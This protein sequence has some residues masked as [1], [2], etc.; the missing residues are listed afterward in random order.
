MNF[1]EL[2]DEVVL[3]TS[4]PDLRDNKIKAAVKM[5]TLK[6]HQSDYYYKDVLE[7]PLQFSSPNFLQ[8]I[9]YRNL[10]PRFRAIKYLRKYDEVGNLEG[11]FLTSI[12]PLEARDSYGYTQLDVYYVAGEVI[13]IRG[14]DEITKLLF[15]CYI[16][17]DIK[18]ESFNS[19]I[20]LD[21]PYAIVADASSTVFK[22][23]GYDEEAAYWQRM[24]QEQLAEIKLSNILPDGS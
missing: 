17:P 20:A 13:Q 12:D 6:A 5:A 9:N 14:S 18:E 23:I 16:N 19:W 21:H 2:L 11:K 22:T 3:I 24:V 8:S 7:Q 4:R 1:G 10:I 15:A